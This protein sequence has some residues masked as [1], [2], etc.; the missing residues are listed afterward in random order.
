MENESLRNQILYKYRSLENFERFADILF[1]QRIYA[2]TYDTMNDPMEGLYKYKIG[3]PEEL[4][5]YLKDE[6]MGIR[7]SCFSHDSTIGL[8]WSYY[9]GGSTGVVIG[10]KIKNEHLKKVEIKYNSDIPNFANGN[11]NEITAREILSYKLNGW[12]H[13]K[14]VR[15]FTDNNSSDDN[16]IE[17]EIVEVIVGPKISKNNYKLIETMVNTINSSQQHNSNCQIRLKKANIEDLNYNITNF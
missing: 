10:V 13:E 7:F 9:A 15:V 2:S 6:K 12:R 17:V 16:F 3:A 5:Q 14:E 4:I 1:H 11:I 8:Q